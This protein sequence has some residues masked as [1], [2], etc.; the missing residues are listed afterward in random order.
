MSCVEPFPR[1]H[2]LGQVRVLA[3]LETKLRTVEA[4]VHIFRGSLHSSVFPSNMTTRS[5]QVNDRMSI[6]EPRD[7]CF[8]VDRVRER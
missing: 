5:H 2:Q 3:Y 8:A 4:P 1:L 7:V 6:T